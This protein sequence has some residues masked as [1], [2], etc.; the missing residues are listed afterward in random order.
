MEITREQKLQIVAL[1]AQGKS[2]KD[3][4]RIAKVSEAKVIAILTNYATPKDST[5]KTIKPRLTEEE[6]NDIYRLA[7]EG[8]G[9]CEIA[10][11]LGIAQSTVSRRL[12]NRT[13]DEAPKPEPAP[14]P[15]PE[16]APKSE[17]QLPTAPEAPAEETKEKEPAPAPTETSSKLSTDNN[18]LTHHN[19]NTYRKACQA[20]YKKAEVAVD[21]ILEIYSTMTETEQRAFDLG[22]AY[23]SMYV[24]LDELRDVAKEEK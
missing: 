6:I 10:R 21:T 9:V 19:D 4:A 12:I 8:M 13:R 23:H 7:D 24:V 22:E 2:V 18:N 16:P 5:T 15:D 17:P 11:R 14:A 1:N 3:I 20:A